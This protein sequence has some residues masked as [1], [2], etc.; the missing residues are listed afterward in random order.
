MKIVEK[1][2]EQ[3]KPYENNPRINDE[4]IE[5]VAE[6]IKQF[7]FKVP[8]II[9][10][11]GVIITGH[12]RYKA[13][14][15]LNLEKVPCIIADDLTPEQIK[16]FRVADNKVAEFAEWDFE[17]LAAELE[18]LT[19]FDIDMSDFGFAE[20]EINDSDLSEFFT[21]KPKEEN[22]EETQQ[23]REQEENKEKIVCPHC[24]KA[25]KI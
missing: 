8:I 5:P 3:L 12:T 13:A 20:I 15:L 11:Y 6:S 9:D 25:F 14:Q 16:A 4:A 21:E 10:K 24:R 18:E 23:E 1:S 19:A 2:L 17:L 22:Q 7:G